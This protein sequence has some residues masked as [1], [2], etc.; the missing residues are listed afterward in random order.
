MR[1]AGAAVCDDGRTPQQTSRSG[2]ARASVLT[3]GSTANEWGVLRDAPWQVIAPG[4]AGIK[5]IVE[6]SE[7]HPKRPG[8]RREMG[9]VCD[10]ACH[11]IAGAAVHLAYFY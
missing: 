1:P 7:R 4:L 6:L 5:Q 11:I 2:P 9:Q 3:I 8:V 10:S